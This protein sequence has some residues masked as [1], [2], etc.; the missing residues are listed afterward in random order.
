[1]TPRIFQVYLLLIFL[2]ACR[3]QPSPISQTEDY[4]DSLSY[5]VINEPVIPLK[6]WSTKNQVVV[7]WLAEPDQLHPNNGLS[8]AKNE[9]FIYLHSFL[10]LVDLRT[11]QLTPV[12]A[13]S[14]PEISS[15]GMKI[16]FRLKNFARWDDG[17]GITADDVAFTI[18]AGKCKLTENPHQKSIWSNLAG[19]EKHDSLTFTLRMKNPYIQNV[20]MWVDLPIIQRKFY[21]PEGLL[22]DFTVEQ[23]DD[24][25]IYRQAAVK[26]WAKVYNSAKYSRQVGFIS[27][28]GPYLLTQWIAGQSITLTRKKNCWSEGL[29][30]LYFNALPETLIFKIIRDPYAVSLDLLAQQ[31]D[32]SS[33]MST[34]QLLQLR[35]DSLF[36]RNYH[37]RFVDSFFFTYAGMNNK[38]E[39]TGRKKLFNLTAVRKAMAYLTP[40]DEMNRVVNK[41]INKRMTGPVSFLKKDFNTRLKPIPYSQATA[42][43]LLSDAGW[44]DTDGNRILDKVIDGEKTEFAFSI[45]YMTTAPEWKDM[46]T[47]MADAYRKA[48]MKVELLPVDY[49][50]WISA[51][52]QLNYDM[53]LGSWGQSSL[54]DDFTQ[55]WHTSS[56]L[57]GGSNFSGFGNADSDLLIDSIKTEMDDL[58]Y[59]ELSARFQQLVYDE[60][61]VIFLFA[62]VRR[63]AVH[64]RFKNIELY[65]DRPGI[66]LNNL[67][68]I[69]SADSKP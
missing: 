11:N 12:L 30:G 35:E 69:Q 10:L 48:G 47:L 62:S 61:P 64:K 25:L 43:K 49:P 41:G 1:M 27:G 4:A 17:T 46:A 63:M 55:L 5:I 68:L 58:K 56:I 57:S 14:L 2:S 59:A 42:M 9:L 40:V 38:P 52:Q 6:D 32:V 44:T 33:A 34:R 24:S 3:Q 13:E 45:M 51:A 67:S 23:M 36:N 29:E 26:Q 66:L 65:F 31:S 19:F 8:A 37:S 39:L 20:A 60:Q 21:D 7:Q 16:K 54:R 53:M 18:K 50:A 15:D 22:D 28:A